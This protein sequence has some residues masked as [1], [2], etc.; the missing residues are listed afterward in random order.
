MC[1]FFGEVSIPILC[2]PLN[3]VYIFLL[4]SCSLH[5]LYT[6]S[7]SDVMICKYFLPFRGLSFPFL[8]C[9]NFGTEGFDFDET[10]FIHSFFGCVC[11]WLSYRRKHCLIQGHKDLHLYFFLKLLRLYLFH[12]GLQSILSYF[13]HVLRVRGPNT[14][15]SHI[16]I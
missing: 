2:L 14:S 9:I 5:R 13:L 7:S 15:L 1:I 10:P 16:D 12:L 8:D 3:W 4:L 6:R 11:F